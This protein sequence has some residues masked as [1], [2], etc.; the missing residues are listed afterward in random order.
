MLAHLD[1][2][3][4]SGS[5][6]FA[7]ALEIYASE[8]AGASKLWR[9][10]GVGR[11]L[12]RPRDALTL[13]RAALALHRPAPDA[14]RPRVHA[15]IKRELLDAAR[16]VHAALLPTFGRLSEPAR[17][18]ELARLLR[19]PA[20]AL[21][22]QNAVGEWVRGVCTPGARGAQGMAAMAAFANMMGLPVPLGA[23]NGEDEDGEGAA[24]ADFAD[25]LGPPGADEFG[26]AWDVGEGLKARFDGWLATAHRVGRAAGILIGAAKDV[27]EI[28][29]WLEADDVVDAVVKK[30]VGSPFAVPFRSPP[31]SYRYFSGAPADARGTGSRHAGGSTSLTRSMRCAASCVHSARRSG[32]SRSALSAASR[33]RR[34]APRASPPRP[35]RRLRLRL[36]RLH[37]LLRL[38]PRSSRP[39]R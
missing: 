36:G 17:V 11:H 35:A 2:V 31:A 8:P 13:Q 1:A 20:G 25:V 4:L 12:L 34:A 26:D 37:H 30:C 9:L 23:L 15:L 32:N 7:A 10:L 19:L 14:S 21:A 18:A 28:L 27:R 3:A 5:D 38:R 39:P 24:F 16:T 22:R 29:P 33:R 6:T